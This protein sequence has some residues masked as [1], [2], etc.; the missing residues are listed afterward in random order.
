M[1]RLDARN[2]SKTLFHA[3]VHQVYKQILATEV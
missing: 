3:T 2:S 1:I